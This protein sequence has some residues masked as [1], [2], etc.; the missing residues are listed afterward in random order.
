MS[1]SEQRARRPCARRPRARRPRALVLGV[2]LVL[3]GCLAAADR[4]PAAAPG[5]FEELPVSVGL[6]LGAIARGSENSMWF[7]IFNDFDEPRAIGRMAL[8]GL[9]TG[10]FAIPVGA[11]PNM[12]ATYSFPKDLVA[13]PDGNMWFVDDGRNEAGQELI[14][15]ITPAGRIEEFPVPASGLPEGIKE[16]APGGDGNMWFIGSYGIGR[17]G[18]NGVFLNELTEF[19]RPVGLAAGSDGSIWF[20]DSEYIGRITPTGEVTE[21][22]TPGIS[23]EDVTQG[24][25]GSMWFLGFGGGNR[26][27]G[28]ITPAGDISEFPTPNKPGYVGW[29]FTRGSD[30]NLWFVEEGVKALWR[31]TPEGVFTNFPFTTTR[32]SEPTDV[33]L[34]ADGN[35]WFIDS[36]TTKDGARYKAY[37]W[38]FITPLAPVNV[39]PPVLSGQAVQDQAL[40][41]SEGSW[42]NGPN[43]FVYQW[44]L[45]NASG[46]ECTN[47]NGQ[48]GATHLLTAS[49]VNH[50]LRA[51]V[52]ASNVGGTAS[53]LSAV[54]VVVGPP[55][56]VSSSS[57][58]LPPSTSATVIGTTMTWKF[59]LSRTYTKVESLVAHRLPVGGLVLVTCH[60][61]GCVF[62]R[63]R[64][65]L[66]AHD[67][68]CRKHHRCPPPH[69]QRELSLAG[70][71][72]NH[73]LGAGTRLVVSIMKTGLIG[74][75][76]IFT[77]NS[78]RQPSVQV[79]CSTSAPAGGGHVC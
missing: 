56:P 67:R 26:L 3:C 9:I 5:T 36:T 46:G 25:S 13:G 41:V 52:T 11:Q 43:T 6:Q 68:P 28:L 58:S 78:G 73:G 72:K 50:T 51:V 4:A 14:G 32:G 48:I 1:P 69:V 76:F 19:G 60:G 62:A 45:C 30:G 40:A 47:M 24:N 34:G 53:A 75:D 2:V 15:R 10:E 16:I 35:I 44:Q 42:S 65:A 38:R 8:N 7:P 23:L 64:Y 20:T 31:V 49:D 61:R 57:S 71:F 55:P 12:P 17:I 79:R 22:P 63:K 59:K 18:L 33:T 66:K 77:M 54:A 29:S 74:K 27:I 21:F 70:L 39:E 37:I